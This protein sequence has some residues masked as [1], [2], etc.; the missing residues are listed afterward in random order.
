VIPCIFVNST[1]VRCF[2]RTREPLFLFS[3]L[4]KIEVIILVQLEN[5]KTNKRA[6]AKLYNFVLALLFCH[7]RG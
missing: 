2:S 5:K 6:S 7:V 4:G 1:H 3:G